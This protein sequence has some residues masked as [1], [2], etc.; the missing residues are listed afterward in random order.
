MN[1]LRF[2]QENLCVLSFKGALQ[3]KHTT[4]FRKH[5]STLFTF[6]FISLANMENLVIF[7]ILL[8]TATVFLFIAVHFVSVVIEPMYMRIFEKPVYVFF[9]PVLKKISTSQRFILENR[10]AFYRRLSAKKK[11][12]FEHRVFH[13]LNSY[14]FFGKDGLVVTEEMRIMV[15]ATYVM[16]TF[17]FRLYLFEVFDKI[18]IYPDVYQ[19]TIS[20]E[21]HKGEFNPRVKAVVF[22]WRHFLEGYDEHNDNLNLG[23]HEF[24]HILHYYGLQRRDNG[25]ALF[26]HKYDRIMQEV[27]HPAN[28][29][30]LIDSTYFRIYGYTN[31]FEFVAVLLE[32]FFETPEIFKKEFPVLYSHVRAMI[33]YRES[34]A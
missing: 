17:G 22:S 12:Y 1:D 26:A 30:K 25:A 34:R 6:F 13:F 10:F 18:I 8:F 21:L 5:H 3:N 19:S 16:L 2:L 7:F 4:Q 9:Y 23:I 11:G 32:H 27:Q 15:A 14:D 29:Q 24:A 33:N 31:S 28:R 20:G